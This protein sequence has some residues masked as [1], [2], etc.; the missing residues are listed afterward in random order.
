M[1]K[2]RVLL[3]GVALAALMSSALVVPAQGASY[4]APNAD[5]QRVLNDT[6]KARTSRGLKPL[7]LDKAMTS[8]AQKWSEK[9]AAKRAM[10]HNPNFARQ[11]PAGWWAA[12]EN[13]ASGP[14]AKHVVAVWMASA[15]HRAN[16]LGNYTHI[17]IGI[18]NGYSTQVFGKYVPAPKPVRP[19]KKLTA[20]PTPTISGTAKVGATLTANASTWKPATVQISYGWL[21]AGKAIK[22]ATNRTYKL[23]AA[24]AGASI[25]VKVTGKKS[26]YT[27]V[28]KTSAPKTVAKK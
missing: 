9:Q 24:D 7:I 26:G 13:I 16:I 25:T 23:T 12:A 6:N 18:K 19:P 2:I 14:S 4:R 28:T 15:G 11:I 5:I 20:A 27:T 10:T 8:V 21:K 3:A 17:G 22:G 1:R